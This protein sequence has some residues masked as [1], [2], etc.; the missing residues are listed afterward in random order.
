MRLESVV[1][2]EDDRTIISISF[3]QRMS[4]SLPFVNALLPDSIAMTG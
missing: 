1:C 2:T 4:F 3:R